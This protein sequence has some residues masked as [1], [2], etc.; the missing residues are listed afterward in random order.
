MISRLHIENYALID[1]LDI[2]FTSGLNIITGETGAGKSIILGALSLLLGERAAT[3]AIRVPDRKSIVEAEFK[4]EGRDNLK[5]WAE[6]ND[7]D[8]YN[9]VCI[10]RREI[11]P[12]GRSRAFINDTPVNIAVLAELGSQLIDIHSQNQNQLLAKPEYQ[13]Q[14][15]DSI[16]GA[17]KLLE[18]YHQEY[19]QWRKAENAL[20]AARKTIEQNRTDE[21]FIR[22]RLAQL[23]EAQLV[24]GEQE[25]LESERELQANMTQIKQ[26]LTDALSLLTSGESSALDNLS[27]AV[28]AT[29][30]LAEVL[31]GA[32]EL[33]KR[34]ETARVEIQDIA[35]TLSDFDSNLN[36]DP[37]LLEQIEER[38]G[39]IYSLEQRLKV[40]S[41]EE[42][43]GIRDDL[44]RKLELIV[45]GDVALDE[46]IIA[47]KSAKTKAT[48][49]ASQLTE[50][51]KA[52]A[53]KF[54]QELFK[55]ASPL[56]MPNLQCVISVTPTSE[57]T[58]TGTDNVEFLFA[59]N[60]NQEPQ[61]VGGSASGGEVSRLMLSI[62][63]I[64]V[65]RLQL[66][67]I[68]FDEVDTGVSGDVANRMGAMMLSIANQLQVIT[69]TH[70]PQVAAKGTI[71]FKVFKEDD[72][73]S[74]H[75]RIR[76]LN[77]SERV[78]E[79]ALMLSGSSIDE[80]ALANAKSLLK[81]GK[82]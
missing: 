49:T 17:S 60:K 15:I 58:P 73:D 35:E 79:L 71:H 24:A 29:E 46:L 12:G 1:S 69:I 65:G 13:L 77:D 34:L 7:L 16:S 75:T 32:S 10:I 6:A 9:S 80:A 37:Q 68:V 63:S 36:A 51:R 64:V 5:L 76:R 61:A 48:E 27:G 38:L 11:L 2:E 78:G 82:N 70:L 14:I 47:A 43:I 20:A 18:Q 30:E 42:L 31:E 25:E 55:A 28:D 74:T 40:N 66:P 3:K 39:E 67:S 56:G 81:N 23:E 72:A 33:A 50:K 41:V 19:A 4:I 45:D 53:R 59:F 57:L 8:W 62:K 21:E 54:S 26:T 22:F 52:A 44:R